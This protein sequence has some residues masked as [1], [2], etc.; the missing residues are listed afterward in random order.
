MATMNFSIPED[1]KQ[2]FNRTFTGRN[3]SAI[4]AELMERAIEEEERRER[5]S[6]AVSRLDARRSDR[7][8]ASAE[9]VA[10]VRERFRE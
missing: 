9:Q 8:R 4:V 3:K 10:V 7:P 2:A 1:V 6:M 5:R